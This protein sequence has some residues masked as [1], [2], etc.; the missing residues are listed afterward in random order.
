MVQYNR[1]NI[2]LQELL[3]QISSLMIVIQGEE[4][5]NDNGLF[6]ISLGGTD[7]GIELRLINKTS[8]RRYCET[9]E[10]IRDIMHLYNIFNVSTEL[11][12]NLRY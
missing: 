2:F 6:T 1:G 10:I 7:A 3:C 12:E 5:Y 11:Y 4:N 8:I 9:S